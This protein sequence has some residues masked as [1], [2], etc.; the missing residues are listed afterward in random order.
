LRSS[1]TRRARARLATM[2][3]VIGLS[4]LFGLYLFWRGG[5]WLLNHFLYENN[6]FAIHE[7]EVKTD[8]VIAL[9]QLRRW[10]GV[11][12]ED[13]LLA[14]DLARAKRDLE[15]IPSIKSVAVERDLPHTLKLRITEREPIALVHFP[16][17]L[18]NRYQFTACS[19]DAEGY[20][21]LPLSPRQRSVPVPTNEQLPVIIGMLS[22]DLRPG[23]KVESPQVQ[24]ALQLITAFDRSLMAGLVELQRI[25]VSA[26]DILQVST[27]Q[28]NAVTFRLA[29]LESQV[30]RWRAIYD[31]GARNNK[32]ITTLDLSVSNH[33][34]VRWTEASDAVPLTPKTA[35]PSRS[36]KKNV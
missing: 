12:L 21:M 26:P 4:T 14:L 1:E 9:E 8:G 24:A 28:G 27:E 20:V 13:N 18:A 34:P 7:I 22:S 32:L 33:V 3:A 10:S 35:R 30:Q 2:A 25:D 19:L 29:D 36:K 31:L 16:Q 23:R 6:A 11:K 17:V 5:E 15:L